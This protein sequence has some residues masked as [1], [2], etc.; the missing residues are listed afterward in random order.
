[1]RKFETDRDESESESEG[2]SIMMIRHDTMRCDTMQFH[3]ISTSNK[4]TRLTT[5][6]DIIS[7]MKRADERKT[8]I[9]SRPDATALSC[10]DSAC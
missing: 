4:P 10:P 9:Y 2:E 6:T 8:Q 3:S 7:I 5:T 1:M